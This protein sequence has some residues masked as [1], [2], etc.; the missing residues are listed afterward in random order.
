[1]KVR[2]GVYASTRLW[3]AL[4]PWD[5]YLARVHAV[6]LVLPGAVFCCESAAAL[7]GMPIFGDP[8]VVHVLVETSGTARLDAGVRS[9]R[10]GHDRTIIESSGIA[11]TSP[12]DTAI[13]LARHRHP[14]IGRS[15]ADAALRIDPLL[16]R[17]V[18]AAGNE[19]RTSSRGR[20]IARWALTRSTARAE[21][22]LESVGLC[23]IEWLGFPAPELQVVFRS[24]S[25]TE[26]RGDALWRSLG[27]VG[28]AD[29][30][31]KYDGR[32][33]DAASVLRR[34]HLR[35]RRLRRR[36]DVT[37]VVH[38]G[39]DDA[40]SVTPLQHILLGA[41]LRPIAP[42]Q[43][44]PLHSVRRNLSARAPHRLAAHSESAREQLS[45]EE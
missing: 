26:D 32:F 24:E 5:R 14:A 18:L 33:G 40:T 9:H 6:A 41:G 22:A 36:A 42:E 1:M 35:D 34:Q 44:A 39:W 8:V 21:T 38:W 12:A 28:E 10:A 3:K 15:A 45:A 27:I 43:P 25:G 30:D 17:D 23:V 29:G 11:L 13:D 37:A 7:L 20:N 2:H 16:T 4:T 31:L 19:A